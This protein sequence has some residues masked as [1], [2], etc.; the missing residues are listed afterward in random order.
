MSNLKMLCILY[1]KFDFKFEFFMKFWYRGQCPRHLY[2]V[3]WPYMMLIKEL[4]KKGRKWHIQSKTLL[5]A[6]DYWLICL[7]DSFSG[8]CH[9]PTDHEQAPGAQISQKCFDAQKSES[10]HPSNTR[11]HCRNCHDWPLI[12]VGG[13]TLT[14]LTLD[15]WCQS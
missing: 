6:Q 9:Q 10:F 3:L 15:H 1:L 13:V 12:L 2:S 11:N 7:I 14:L 8:S 5:Y 4:T